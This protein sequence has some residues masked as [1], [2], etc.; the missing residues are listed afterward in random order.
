MN[1]AGAAFMR[2]TIRGKKR[3][4]VE[5]F[6]KKGLEVSVFKHF[7]LS[8]GWLAGVCDCWWRCA[9]GASTPRETPV[10]IR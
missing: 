10:E 6:D 7:F 4:F 5:S 1:A 2:R 9:V 8:H 3:S